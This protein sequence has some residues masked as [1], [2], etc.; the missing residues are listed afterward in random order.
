MLSINEEAVELV[1]LCGRD[2]KLLASE[3]IQG[4][5]NLCIGVSF[6]PPMKHAPGHV[7]EEEEEVIYCLE[8]TGQ[9]I[10]G[11]EIYPIKPGTVVF[12]P[13]KTLHSI[14]NTGDKTIKLLYVFSPPAKIGQYKDYKNE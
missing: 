6:F 14:N 8:G 5:K 4:C 3:K 11:S 9:A 12:F 2:Y 1:K 10:V 13:P 7:H